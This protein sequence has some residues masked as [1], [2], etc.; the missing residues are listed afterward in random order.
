MENELKH[1]NLSDEISL[2]DE[3]KTKTTF[4]ALTLPSSSSRE[5]EST[6]VQSQTGSTFYIP[7]CASVFYVMASSG[8][9]CMFA[10][11]V[12]LSVALVAMINQTAVT[13]DVVTINIT[14]ISNTEQCPRDP[15]LQ[16]VDGEFTWD[17][18]QQGALLAAIFYGILIT[19]VWSKNHYLE[20]NLYLECNAISVW[21]IFGFPWLRINERLEYKLLLRTCNKAIT[22]S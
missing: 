20:T 13:D 19:Q 15:A 12:S 2:P 16:L 3:N 5:V 6:T 18:H 21:L 4:G 14:N 9:L 7:F 8:F 17:R 1:E 11:R 22:P 10:M